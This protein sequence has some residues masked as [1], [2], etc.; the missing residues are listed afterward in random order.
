MKRLFT[1]A[2]ILMLSWATLGAQQP[3]FEVKP[4]VVNKNSGTLVPVTIYATSS[5]NDPVRLEIYDVFGNLVWDSVAETGGRDTMKWWGTTNGGRNVQSG[6]YI[7]I[8]KVI[9]NGREGVKDRQWIGVL[10]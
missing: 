7:L 10:W 3:G 2:G 1:A 4:N 6:Q 8:I 5:F 9:E